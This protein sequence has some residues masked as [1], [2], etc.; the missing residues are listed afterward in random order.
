MDTFVNSDG[1]IH[2][3][4]SFLVEYLVTGHPACYINFPEDN[5][6]KY[7]SSI[8]KRC[9]DMCYN[10]VT[11]E[12]ILSYVRNVVLHGEDPLR[13]ARTQ[14]VEKELKVNYPHAARVALQK[15]KEGIGLLNDMTKTEEGL[16]T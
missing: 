5:Y 9:R 6:E 7:Y 8:G 15:I 13:E 1:I 12:D 16:Q 11:Q 14:F 3:C 10:A 2:D 4:W